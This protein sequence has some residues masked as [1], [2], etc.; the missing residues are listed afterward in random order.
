MQTD[1]ILIHIFQGDIVSSSSFSSSDTE[2]VFADG[3]LEICS[4]ATTDTS[5]DTSDD[6][7]QPTGDPV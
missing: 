4:D 2:G 6:E 3:P 7:S 1:H 5:D